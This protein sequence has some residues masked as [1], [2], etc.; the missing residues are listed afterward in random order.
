MLNLVLIIYYFFIMENQKN[1]LLF[2]I[3]ATLHLFE[4]FMNSFKPLMKKL[5]LQA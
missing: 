2:K 1:F 5:G 4:I 3:D